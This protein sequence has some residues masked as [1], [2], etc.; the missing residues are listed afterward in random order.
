[1]RS[2][3]LSLSCVILIA[4]GASACAGTLAWRAGGIRESVPRVPVTIG[5][6]RP[7][8]DG[9]RRVQALAS[10]A[11]GAYTSPCTLPETKDRRP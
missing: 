8:P 5:V 7:N 1:M 10:V 2:K 3:S 9:W 11:W 6:V 4:G